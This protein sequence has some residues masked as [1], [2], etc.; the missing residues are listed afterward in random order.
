[1]VL[2]NLGLGLAGKGGCRTFKTDMWAGVV[3]VMSVLGGVNFPA[4]VLFFL[5]L[6]FLMGGTTWDGG[7]STTEG[8]AGFNGE[9]E[10]MLVTRRGGMDGLCPPCPSGVTAVP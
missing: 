7:R 8:W 1:V 6:C 2:F 9:E 10:P 3:V 4:L 5:K